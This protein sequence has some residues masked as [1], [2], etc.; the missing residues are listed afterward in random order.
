MGPVSHSQGGVLVWGHGRDRY[1]F[2]VAGERRGVDVLTHVPFEGPAAIADRALA[3]GLRVRIHRL[4][5]GDPVPAAEHIDRLVVMGGPMGALDDVSYPWLREVRELLATMVE[6]EVPTLGVCLGAQLLAAAC[7]AS[8]YPGPGPE[9]GPGMVRLTSAALDDPMF[10]VV[11]DGDL[12]VFHWHGDTFD[13]P[14][15]AT[16]LASSD[17][18]VHQAFRVANAWGLQFHVELRAVDAPSVSDHLGAGLA[19]SSD[20]LAAI[21]PTGARIIDAFLG[22]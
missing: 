6:R 8:V 22:I 12:A 20:D 7:G 9:I 18:Y 1:R 13:L 4:F 14:R 2:G 21:E 10:G 11:D 16:L 5:A 3:A 19:V 17:A 15:G